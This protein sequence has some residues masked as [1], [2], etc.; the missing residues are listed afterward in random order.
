MGKNFPLH[1]SDEEA[2]PGDLNVDL[3]YAYNKDYVRKLREH[4]LG[5]NLGVRGTWPDGISLSVLLDASS[6]IGRQRIDDPALVMVPGYPELER[7][8]APIPVYP[9]EI[10]GT[11]TTDFSWRQNQDRLLHREKLA[12][13]TDFFLDEPAV[14][15]K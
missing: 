5:A 6:T 7:E 10:S 2:R 3:S 9:S 14:L 8:P 12:F 1:W 4:E 11:L 15:E 13:G